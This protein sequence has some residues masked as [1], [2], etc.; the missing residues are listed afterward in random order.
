MELWLEDNE[1]SLPRRLIVTYESLPGRPRF[2]AE[3]SN[4]DFTGPPDTAFVFQP[5][6]GV[7]QV[8]MA[9]GSSSPPT[10]TK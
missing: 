1:R 2:I 4:W 7:T 8:E 6:A 3:L 10:T 9:A 5:P